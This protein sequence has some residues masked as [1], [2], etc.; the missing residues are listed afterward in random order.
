MGDQAEDPAAA[1]ATPGMVD[2]TVSLPAGLLADYDRGVT[3]GI[4]SCRDEALRHGLTDSWRHHRGRYYTLRVDLLDPEDMRPDT[5]AEGEPEAN[6]PET[7]GDN[8]NT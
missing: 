6:E 4:Y 1:P 7:G 5:N 2:V 8:D 3:A